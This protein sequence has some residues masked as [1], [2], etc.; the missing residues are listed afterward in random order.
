MISHRSTLERPTS[1]PNTYRA[2]RSK[3]GRRVII[4]AAL[5]AAP[6]TTAAAQVV[7][8]NLIS[9]PDGSRPEGIAVGHGTTFYTGSLATG[10]IFR[11]DLRSGEVTTLFPGQVG[12]VAVGMSFDPR[13]GNLFVAGGP[14]GEAYVYD[15][16]TGD[17]QAVYS[18]TQDFSFINDVIVT[19]SA[20]YY[21]DSFRPVLYRVPLGPGGEL[22]DG[23][24]VQEILLGGDFT[25]VPGAFNTNGIEATADGESLII[26]HSALGLLYH[27]DPE[28][29]VASLIDLA[30]ET[31]E[32]GDGILL[33]G[34]T[35]YVVQNQQNQIAEI[36]MS[37]DL[38]AGDVVATMT[39]DDFDVPTT[40]AKFGRY[41]Y[42]VNARFGT[43]PT[44]ETPYWVVQVNR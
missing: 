8:P 20:A 37:P 29:G 22:P 21:T 32:N 34:M 26:V 13:T 1:A 39:N 18:L 2:L 25:F 33:Q 23:P 44:P 19:R 30:G 6:L 11:G 15:G 38:T 3:G 7:F 43:P 31:V 35:L 12:R 24:A 36:R 16:G 41:L 14:T 10:A 42:A 5:V 40:I 28:T 27:V 4:A 17:E 9:L